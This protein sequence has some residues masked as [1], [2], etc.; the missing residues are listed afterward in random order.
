MFRNTDRVH[1]ELNWMCL[2][3]LHMQVIAWQVVWFHAASDILK[4]IQK[5]GYLLLTP[6][7]CLKCDENHKFRTNIK[8]FKAWSMKFLV[9]LLNSP[10]DC[11][12]ERSHSLAVGF[13]LCICLLLVTRT[14]KD[15]VSLDAPLYWTKNTTPRRYIRMDTLT[16]PWRRRRWLP[17]SIGIERDPVWNFHGQY[18]F[19]N[20]YR[21]SLF[22]KLQLLCT[23]EK[24]R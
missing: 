17:L 5:D 7:S 4:T 11:N 9:L 8:Y 1:P 24:A 20:F 2:V 14:N 19:Y 12:D 23:C 18:R 16:R 22:A 21:K 13:L 15:L 3:R 10:M 6:L